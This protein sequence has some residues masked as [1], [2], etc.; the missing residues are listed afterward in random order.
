MPTLNLNCC[1]L[2]RFVDSSII[3]KFQL[4]HEYETDQELNRQQQQQQNCNSPFDTMG[5]GDDVQRI[6]ETASTDKAAVLHKHH[7]PGKLVRSCRTSS[8]NT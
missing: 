1:T 6:N 3:F 4:C 2:K 7:H 8:H 5:S